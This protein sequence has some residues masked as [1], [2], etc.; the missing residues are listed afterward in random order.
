LPGTVA[1]DHHIVH[2][3][4]RRTWSEALGTDAHLRQAANLVAVE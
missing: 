2:I 4:G 3:A 1:R